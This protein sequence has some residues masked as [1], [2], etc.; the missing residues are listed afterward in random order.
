MLAWCYATLLIDT[1]VVAYP[2]PL[3]LQAGDL[4]E[5]IEFSLFP[6]CSPTPRSFSIGAGSLSLLLVTAL[7]EEGDTHIYRGPIVTYYM[8]VVS[9]NNQD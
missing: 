5:K 3:E 9:S 8:C 7:Q 6:A 1:G 4:R 2:Q